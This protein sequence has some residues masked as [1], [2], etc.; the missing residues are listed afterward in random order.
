MEKGLNASI[1]KILIPETT[2]TK[3]W[4]QSFVSNINILFS[5]SVCKF[6]TGLLLRAFSGARAEYFKVLPMLC[7]NESNE[8]E[9]HL[10]RDCTITLACL[11]Q[12]ILPLDVIPACLESITSVAKSSSWKAKAAVLDLLQVSYLSF[13]NYQVVIAQWLARRLA[14]GDKRLATGEVLGSNPS[15]EDNLLISD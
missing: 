14:T 3:S 4:T 12:A 11:A 8:F 13:S 2:L 6:L 10:A 15:K 5:I 1:L 9:P 7:I